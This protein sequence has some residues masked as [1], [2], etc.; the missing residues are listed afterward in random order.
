MKKYIS[1]LLTLF[2]TILSVTVFA[3]KPDEKGL[4][5]LKEYGI[6]VGD[7]DGDLRLEDTITRAEAAKMIITLQ[8]YAPSTDD[9]HFFEKSEFP[10][11]WETHWAKPYI[12]MAKMMGIVEG[13]ENGNFNPEN[14]ITNE[15]IV[16]MLVNVLGYSPM[17]ETTG[18][19]PGGYINTSSR[20]G[21]TDGLVFEVGEAA[22]RSDVAKLFINAL[23]IPLMGQTK[24][25]ADGS[26]EY[27]IFD[28][29]NAERRTILS[30]YWGVKE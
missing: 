4:E 20:T 5:T 13:D 14:N 16:K 23:D 10:D 27:T 21:L 18:G 1:L 12:N 19:F 22:V 24:W 11:V 17:A 3:E 8:N 30:E 26:H 9:L 6:M 28:G 7:P 29:N 2:V 15:E 25:S